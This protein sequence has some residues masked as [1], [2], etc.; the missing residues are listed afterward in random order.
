MAYGIEE[1]SEMSVTGPVEGGDMVAKPNQMPVGAAALLSKMQKKNTPGIFKLPSPDKD[2]PKFMKVAAEGVEQ[3]TAKGDT[4][5]IM[6]G[7]LMRQGIDTRGMQ[8]DDVIR[9]YEQ[10]FGSQ[11]DAGEMATI[12][13]TDWR[14]ILKMIESGMSQEDI[15]EQ[16]AANQGGMKNYLGEETVV[17]DAPKRWQSSPDSPE[18][19]LAYITGAEKDLLLKANLHGSLDDGIPNQGPSGIISLDGGGSYKDETAQRTVKSRASGNTSSR[20]SYQD[21]NQY[22]NNQNRRQGA[23]DSIAPDVITNVKSSQDT[24]EG[25]LLSKLSDREKKKNEAKSDGGSFMDMFNPLKK[26][27]AFADGVRDF[28]IEQVKKLMESLGTDD[29]AVGLGNLLRALGNEDRRADFFARYGDQDFMEDILGDPASKDQGFDTE[30]SDEEMFQRFLAKAEAGGG[31]KF[32]K[33]YKPEEYYA[34]EK[35]EDAE[36]YQKRMNKKGVTPQELARLQ[37][38]GKID[39]TRANTMMIEE[40]RK[41]SSDNNKNNSGGGGG[42]PTEQVTETE[43]AE[44]ITPDNKSSQF[45]IG[46][47]MPYKD[48]VLTGGV[49]KDVPVGRRFQIG[50]D[51]AIVENRTLNDLMKYATLGGYNQLEPFQNYQARRKKFL[52]EEDPQYFDEDGNIIYSGQA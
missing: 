7:E 22:D 6:A 49:E 24:S 26:F 41:R 45:A 3:E 11:K 35:G 1:L 13:P 14:S 34:S 20:S 47:T 25:N 9:I 18:T 36:T 31:D 52:G 42:R 16:L 8:M 48:D 10:T 12:D 5:S 44:T 27:D 32:L 50:K 33:T 23:I 43:I 39:F 2:M 30:T 37:R 21:K 19:E 4:I 38:E 40:G 29:K 15:D 46:G 17:E 51:G 28:E